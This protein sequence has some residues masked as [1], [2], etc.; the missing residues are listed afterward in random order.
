MKIALKI[1]FFLPTI[2]FSLLI[3]L[4]LFDFTYKLFKLKK[5]SSNLKF[6]Y[7]SKI[8]ILNKVSLICGI[9][10]DLTTIHSRH[11]DFWSL[12]GLYLVETTL[13][14]SCT[15]FSDDFIFIQKVKIPYT[16]IESLLCQKSDISKSK[17]RTLLIRSEN[18]KEITLFTNKKNSDFLI[19]YLKDKNDKISVNFEQL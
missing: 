4:D 13:I 11:I 3:I 9:I 6:K 7:I 2:I 14:D 19:S 17:K 15:V 16:T 12:A 18:K 8:N 5:S 1:L 10:I